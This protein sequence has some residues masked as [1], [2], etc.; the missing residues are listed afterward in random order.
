MT[1]TGYSDRIN[2]AFAFAAKHHDQQVRKGT[3]LP[4]FTQP[5]NVAIILTRYGQD[6]RTVVAGILHDIV[7]DGVRE[8]WTASMLEERIGRQ[9]RSRTRSTR[10]SP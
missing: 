2:H 6:E 7:E 3:R 5:A 8:G 9:V 4:Y 10:C 1:V